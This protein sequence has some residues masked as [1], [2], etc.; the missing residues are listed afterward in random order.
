MCAVP[1][2][3]IVNEIVKTKKKRTLIQ[4][5]NYLSLKNS[6]LLIIRYKVLLLL[7]PSLSFFQ[8]KIVQQHLLQD[9]M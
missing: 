3:Q 2:E 6:P 5:D 1:V 9:R 7:N 4:Q 8:K